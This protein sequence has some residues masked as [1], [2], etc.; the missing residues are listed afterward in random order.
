MTRLSQ[1]PLSA[2]TFLASPSRAL[3]GFFSL[4][5]PLL[6]FPFLALH[7][8]GPD[9]TV[10]PFLDQTRRHSQVSPLRGLG[11]ESLS[12]LQ[13]D[14]TQDI[15]GLWDT[16]DTQTVFIHS[17]CV[18]LILRAGSSV[19]LLNRLEPEDI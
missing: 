6:G 12:S 8:C 9:A 18:L 11:S 17:G 7:Q 1:H 4:L 2:V 13:Q 14:I 16:G 19:V 15:T 3:S 5:D 10:S